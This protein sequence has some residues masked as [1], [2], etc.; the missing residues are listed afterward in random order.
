[1]ILDNFKIYCVNLEKEV[2]R[3]KRITKLL[4]N[5]ELKEK[6]VFFKAICKDD[7][8]E[9]FIKE[10]KFEVFSDLFNPE[11]DRPWYKRNVNVGEIGCATSHYFCWLDF[12]NSSLDYAVFMEDDNFWEDKGRLKAEIKEFM[13]LHEK[14]HSVDMIYFGRTRPD[15]ASEKHRNEQNYSEKYLLADYSY[16]THCYMLTKYG[17]KKILGQKPMEK[18]MPLDEMICSMFMDDH[19]HKK[20][21]EAFD[22]CLKVIAIKND[23]KDKDDHKHLGFCF[24]T[25][26]E[27]MSRT[28]ISESEVYET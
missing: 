16:N 11:I 15:H 13:D 19:P 25:M 6:T 4:K 20:I 17:V 26:D 22:S 27:G 12:Y 10:N 28:D 18:I 7:I 24:Q 3:K 1:V 5:D 21:N 8:D 23:E 2:I 9:S 14:D